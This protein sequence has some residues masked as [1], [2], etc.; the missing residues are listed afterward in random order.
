MKAFPTME[1]DVSTALG[2]VLDTGRIFLGSVFSFTS[3]PTETNKNSEL[4]RSGNVLLSALCR[5][6]ILAEVADISLLDHAIIAVRDRIE[7]IVN[8]SS[9]RV[10]KQTLLKSL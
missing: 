5:L 1:A 7:H 3:D 8:T 4:Y 9:S 2:D 10:S 6:L